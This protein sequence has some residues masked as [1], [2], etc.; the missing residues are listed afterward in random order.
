MPEDVAYISS[1]SGVD[2]RA[3]NM[4]LWFLTLLLKAFFKTKNAASGT[5]TTRL[6]QTVVLTPRCLFRLR[7]EL[8][9][10]VQ[11]A[12]DG[13]RQQLETFRNKLA[14]ARR[15]GFHFEQVRSRYV[16]RWQSYERGED[17]RT[18]RR[19]FVFI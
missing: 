5:P 3:G 19:L 1:K 15:L 13:E 16:V 14:D 2:N 17:G 12:V 7:K 9:S 6:L 8:H 18:D 4:V 10:V 11:S